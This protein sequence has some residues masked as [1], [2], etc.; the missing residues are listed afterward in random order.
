[1]REH[2][3]RELVVHDTDAQGIKCSKAPSVC[4][5]DLSGFLVS[6]RA[7]IFFLTERD[8]VPISLL[9]SLLDAH[10]GAQMVRLTINN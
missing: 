7:H 3:V 5:A 9:C 4:Y 1:M 10:F 8:A 6:S 2:F